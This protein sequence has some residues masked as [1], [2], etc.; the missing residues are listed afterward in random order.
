MNPPENSFLGAENPTTRDQ[1]N[2]S[3]SLRSQKRRLAVRLS[4]TGLPCPSPQPTGSPSILRVLTARW[5]PPGSQVGGRHRPA[6]PLQ[7]AQEAQGQFHGLAAPPLGHRE[8]AMQAK[9]KALG[10]AVSLDKPTSLTTAGNQQETKESARW[11]QPSL[12]H[13]TCPAPPL[14]T[15]RPSRKGSK[16]FCCPCGSPCH[17]RGTCLPDLLLYPLLVKS[18]CSLWPDV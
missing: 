11:T 8:A 5:L 10:R 13:R 16:T 14:L 3:F 18:Q 1:H 7:E 4:E 15:E 9:R 6:G 12:A 2:R 17:R